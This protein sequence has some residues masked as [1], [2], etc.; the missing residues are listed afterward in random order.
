M[1]IHFSSYLLCLDLPTSEQHEKCNEM[2][3]WIIKM[4]YV[5][6][7]KTNRFGFLLIRAMSFFT[8]PLE[9]EESMHNT[10]ETCEWTP[11]TEHERPLWSVECAACIRMKLNI[12]YDLLFADDA[13][14]LLFFCGFSGN[15]KR[16]STFSI[17]TFSFLGKHFIFLLLFRS[18]LLLYCRCCSL[19]H[20]IFCCF[21]I[22][23]E[24]SCAAE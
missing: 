19:F 23:C 13:N 7:N 20:F 14:R 5:N 12:F 4:V 11:W 3:A 1:P 21:F 22:H 15:P 10:E 2:R 6:R 8:P 9:A 18:F 17:C 24:K 16:E